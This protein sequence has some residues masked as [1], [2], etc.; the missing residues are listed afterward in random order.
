MESGPIRIRLA[1]MMFG[2]YMIFGAWAAPLASFL[3]FAPADGGLGF[4]PAR[5]SWIYS[6]TAFAG[7]LAP[8]VLGLL[9]DRLFATQRLLGVLH[10]A[11]AAILFAAARF[12]SVQQDALR[13]AGDD[14]WTFG[15]LFV[16]MQANSFVLI[17]TLALCN[18]T[19]L[20]NLREP[21]KSY[22]SIRLFGTVGWIVVNLVIGL[23]GTPVSAQPLYVAAFGSLVMGVYSFTL[24]HTPPVRHGRGIGEA[25]GLPA[26]G[27]FRQADFRVLIGCALCMAAVQQ[28]YAVYANP[29][30]YALGAPKPMALQSL[31]QASEVVCLLA[32]PLV[33]AR[34]GFKVTM[35]IGI[36]GWVARN[37]LFATGW[38]PA[39]AT[40]AL[41]LHGMCLSFFFLVA[42][43]YV[44]RHA[45]PHLR[46]SAQ[47]ILTFTVAGV[48]TLFGNSLS[49]AVLDSLDGPG[50]VPWAW[51]WLVPAATAAAVLALFVSLFRDEAQPSVAVAAGTVGT[52]ELV[53]KT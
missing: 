51:F 49:A 33:L 17:L 45:P 31:A 10:M 14:S 34:Y 15:V 37:L 16:L 20:R 38:L 23:F 4:S 25:L 28:F 35:A 1:L 12:C 5:T 30:L 22:G 39:I 41:P 27:M 24:P 19:G 40:V 48:G 11:G 29:F 44:D 3:R 2:Q 18:V 26:L 42:N 52:Q 53:V 9:A 6:T 47:G 13:V 21:K 7:L 8:M 43:V 32:F 36:L 50:G 46:A